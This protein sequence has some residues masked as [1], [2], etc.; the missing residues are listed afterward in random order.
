M[1]VHP[2]EE[3]RLGAISNVIFD[4]EQMLEIDARL[5]ALHLDHSYKKIV[6]AYNAR[7]VQVFFVK[8]HENARE[9]FE[10][11]GLTEKVGP[12]HIFKRVST[13]ID[14]IERHP[15]GYDTP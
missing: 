2:S 1:S 12:D 3:P 8:I 5:V 9:L 4:V 10:L 15:Q 11:S 14:Y 7:Y 13:A 6:E